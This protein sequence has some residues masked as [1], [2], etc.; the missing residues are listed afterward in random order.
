[1]A[2]LW[3]PANKTYLRWIMKTTTRIFTITQYMQVLWNPLACFILL[4]TNSNLCTR[5]FAELQMFALIRDPACLWGL[6]CFQHE[7]HSIPQKNI[8]I[9]L[10]GS[11]S[12]DIN[13]YC[14]NQILDQERNNSID[15]S[16][17]VF[18]IGANSFV[19]FALEFQSKVVPWK[20]RMILYTYMC[21][22]IYLY[23]YIS[24]KI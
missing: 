16:I 2:H 6:N 9:A 23:I 8:P 12:W 5:G 18:V 4:A 20:L 17:D 3:R 21:I 1:M 13:G 11:L 10:P 14:Q 7:L 22:Y 15:R 19:L 24:I